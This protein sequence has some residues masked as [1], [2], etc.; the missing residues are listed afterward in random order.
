MPFPARALL[1]M[2]SAHGEV[3]TPAR[4]RACVECHGVTTVLLCCLIVAPVQGYTR[5]KIKQDIV[6]T[7]SRFVSD[8]ERVGF[9]ESRPLLALHDPPV[10]SHI[11]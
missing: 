7:G 9:P 5:T 6:I 1:R 11:T 8:A 4:T 10:R 3:N 2:P